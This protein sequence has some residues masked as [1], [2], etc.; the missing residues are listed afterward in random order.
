MLQLWSALEYEIIFPDLNWSLGWQQRLC[1][2]SVSVLTLPFWKC[3]HMCSIQNGSLGMLPLPH[4][5]Q[6]HWG[7]ETPRAFAGPSTYWHQ[8]KVKAEQKCLLVQQGKG[9]APSAA[10]AVLHLLHRSAGW[11][12]VQKSHP[13]KL[14]RREKTHYKIPHLTI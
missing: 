14:I 1:C 12:G 2:I 3:Y 13:D 10:Q 11:E 9:A 6:V 8:G 4:E 5:P 7:V